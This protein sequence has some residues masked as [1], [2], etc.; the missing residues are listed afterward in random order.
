MTIEERANEYAHGNEHEAVCRGC[1][2]WRSL[3]YVKGSEEQIEIDKEKVT[4][5]WN[6]N[7]TDTM[8]DGEEKQWAEDKLKELLTVLEE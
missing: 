2:Y 3:G 6:A 1:Q 5:W 8:P 7:V 4:A